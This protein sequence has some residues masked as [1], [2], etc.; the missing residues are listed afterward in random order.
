MSIKISNARSTIASSLVIFTLAVFSSSQAIATGGIETYGTG[1]SSSAAGSSSSMSGG[2]A[3]TGALIGLGVGLLLEGLANAPTARSE[4]FE[5][6][7][8]SEQLNRES[9]ER[10]RRAMEAKKKRAE[11]ANSNAS[12]DASRCVAF[13]R[14]SSLN[15]FIVNNCN[16][17]IVVRWRDSRFCK[18]GC[19][20]GAPAGGRSS[21]T[22]MKGSY[23]Y[24]ACQGRFCTPRQL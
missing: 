2:S 14:R 1:R 22:K 17:P 21:I 13:D 15:D 6:E 16:V 20:S 11:N 5:Q 7:K 24:T 9:R 8:S 18:T 10:W 12:T 4:T 3:A 23:S 19:M